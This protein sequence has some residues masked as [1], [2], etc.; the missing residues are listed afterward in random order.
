MTDRMRLPGLP[1]R[2][3]SA[4]PTRVRRW[5][6]RLLVA[7]AAAGFV[8]PLSAGLAL[9]AYNPVP[10]ASWTPTSG[11]VYA[12][13]QAGDAVYLGGSFTALWSPAGGQA[14]VR[15]GLAALDAAT[16][17]LLPWNPNA[18]GEVR[19]LETSADGSTVYVGGAFTSI[20]GTTRQRLAAVNATT[21][22]LVTGF[23]AN[24]SATV[25]TLE[26]VGPT[27]YAGGHFTT[28]GGQS[29]QR[30]AAVDAATGALR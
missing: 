17:A 28:L 25:V 15:N 14:V 2:P 8:L 13:A 6:A 27:L 20:G 4:P 18:N 23:T 11:R 24:A 10:R 22:A 21:G 30:L 1:A 9:A 7:A 29:R 19:T 26:R 5:V 16:G 12:I 3:P